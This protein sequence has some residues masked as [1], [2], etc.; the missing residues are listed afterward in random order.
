MLLSL[1]HLPEPPGPE[2][3]SGQ[4][5]GPD[6]AHRC[7]LCPENIETFKYRGMALKSI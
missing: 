7:F 4:P 1:Q 2:V 3:V 6:K 5:W